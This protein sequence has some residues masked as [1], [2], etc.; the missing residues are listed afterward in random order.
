MKYLIGRNN[1]AATI[2][3]PYD[4]GNNCS[5]CTSK[6]MYKNLEPNLELLWKN[7]KLINRTSSIQDVVLTGGEPFANLEVLQQIID[8]ILYKKLILFNCC[9]II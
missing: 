4:C 3:V 8:K 7:L 1:L 6:Q 9:V 2:Y 5:F